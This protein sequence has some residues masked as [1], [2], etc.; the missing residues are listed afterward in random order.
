MEF[1]LMLAHPAFSTAG[2]RQL[3]LL[4]PAVQV[5]VCWHVQSAA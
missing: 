2:T 4:R 3:H 1:V 5:V